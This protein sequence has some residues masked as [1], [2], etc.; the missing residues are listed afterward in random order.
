MQC[1]NG[2][3]LAD[4]QKFCSECGAPAVPPAAIEPPVEHTQVIPPYTPDASWPPPTQ[5]RPGPWARLPRATRWSLALATLV[6]LVGGGT[7]AALLA[8]SKNS[9][10]GV[11]TWLCP[12]ATSD[13]LI[14]WPGGDGTIQGTYETAQLSGTAP[15]Q[16]VSTT[17]GDVTGRTSGSALTINMDDR[18]DWY[19]SIQ[20]NSMTLNVPQENGVIESGTCRRS[21][22]S[23]WNQAVAGLSTQ[24]TGA[25]AS[26][27]AAAAAAQQAQVLAGAQQALTSDVGTLH[28]DASSL[29]TDKTLA[30]DVQAMKND[31]AT[32]QRDWVAEQ[33]DSC[34]NLGGDASTVSGDASTVSGDD[35]GLSGDTDGITSD[36]S[37]LASDI[38]SVQ[39]DLAKVTNAGA[40]PETDPAQALAYAGKVTADTHKALSWAAQQGVNLT[41]SSQS[42]A[43]EASD[44]AS[45]HAC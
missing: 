20:G 41:A 2:H 12:G 6:V 26:A 28:S 40:P 34:S 16:Q 9:E 5:Q 30:S 14:Q 39:D 1:A 21:T 24:V 22:I 10:P 44:F 19:G 45:A 7:A 27:S 35:S 29:D 25:N 23:A 36:L 8:T 31:L 42:I 38:S 13:V 3:E 33:N 18:G 43:Q 15:D 37:N 17:R 32:E 4:Q 11:S